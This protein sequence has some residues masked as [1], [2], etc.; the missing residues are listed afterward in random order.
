MIPLPSGVFTPHL[1]EL[2]CC[3]CD[4]GDCSIYDPADRERETSICIC[5]DCAVTGCG[6]HQEEKA[7]V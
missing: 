2:G 3:D 5:P 1:D 4:C 7:N 6:I